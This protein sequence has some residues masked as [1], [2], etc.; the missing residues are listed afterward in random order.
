MQVVA[1]AGPPAGARLER[2]QTELAE[3]A[4]DRPAGLGL[5]PVI[6]HRLA[7]QVSRPDGGR[8]IA[9]LAGEEQRLQL[10]QVVLRAAACR[11]GPA[12]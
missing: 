7:Q 9:A 6:D 5:P 1:R 8:R 12:A 4:G 11:P 3:A 2:E 10:R